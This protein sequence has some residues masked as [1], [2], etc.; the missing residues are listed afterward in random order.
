M[1]TYAEKLNRLNPEDARELFYVLSSDEQRE[2]IVYLNRGI[3]DEAEA[4]VDPGNNERGR[5]PGVGSEAQAA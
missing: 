4:G 1:C 5:C 3:Y 2:F